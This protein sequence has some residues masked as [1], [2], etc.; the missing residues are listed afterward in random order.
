MWT[1]RRELLLCSQSLVSN[2]TESNIH[3]S[4]CYLQLIQ[5]SRLRRIFPTSFSPAALNSPSW[6]PRPDLP[7]RFWACSKVSSLLLC[8]QET[9]TGS[10]QHNVGVVLLLAPTGRPRSSAC[11]PASKTGKLI[12]GT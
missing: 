10:F 9:S 4:I 11:Q 6:P 1:L 2:L 3:I 12:S 8:A 5:S 7:S